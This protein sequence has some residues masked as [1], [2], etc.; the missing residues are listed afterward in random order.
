MVSN[1][2]ENALKKL[3]IDQTT[4]WLFAVVLSLSL[5]G[6]IYLFL[7]SIAKDSSTS[8]MEYLDHQEA[9]G[10]SQESLSEPESTDAPADKT[11]HSDGATSESKQGAPDDDSVPLANTVGLP[12]WSYK[13]NT[14]PEHWGGLSD[15]FLDCKVGR[16]QSP[17]DINNPLPDRALEPINF[18]YEE[19]YT[20]LRNDGTTIKAN[21]GAGSELTFE[22]D[23]YQLLEFHFHSPSEHSVN[24]IPFD[25]ELHLSHQ[26]KDGKLLALGVFFEEG[27]KPHMEIYD[28][29]KKLPVHSGDESKH[30]R[31]N[32]INLLPKSRQYYTYT[33]SMTIPPC[34]EGVTW[35]LMKKA[36]RISSTQVDQ[37]L[38]AFR[39]N[40][41]PVQSIHHRTIKASSFN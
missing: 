35:I 18:A 25:L 8:M 10:G 19:T 39:H 9:E 23:S 24:G 12:Q 37:F 11:G 15:D 14:G 26:N 5:F 33:G 16:N 21:Y 27:P 2:V 36:V 1:F 28:L 29:W 32:A 41:R 34:S 38:R 30:F 7:S 31:M 13:G 3:G 6:G 22:G 17:V 4:A 40:S 20:T